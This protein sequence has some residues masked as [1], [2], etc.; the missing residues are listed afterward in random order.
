MMPHSKKKRLKYIPPIFLLLL[1]LLSVRLFWGSFQSHG[2]TNDAPPTLFSNPDSETINNSTQ[3]QRPQSA[4]STPNASPS[5]KRLLLGD[6]NPKQVSL[7]ILA[8]GY[9]QEEGHK[10]FIDAKDLTREIFSNETFMPFVQDFNIYALF[11]PSETS[12]LKQKTPIIQSVFSPESPKK[13]VLLPQKTAL[14]NGVT[15]DYHMVLVHTERHIGFSIRTHASEEEE[16]I[17][18]IFAN[19][20]FDA[21]TQNILHELAHAIA[22]LADEYRPLDKTPYHFEA[23]NLTRDPTNVPWKNFFATEGIGVFPV[24]T[25]GWYKPS[26]SCIMMG[27]HARQYPDGRLQFTERD[28]CVVCTDA[29]S[30]ALKYRLKP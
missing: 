3:T 25:T 4:P 14:I 10:F 29:I 12:T 16:S 26:E 24:G 21:L 20:A 13:D 1:C 30:T 2:P 18:V 17:T 6:G 5:H 19:S 11:T 22:D 28:F 15:A 7:A 23:V 27:L 9:T 8:D